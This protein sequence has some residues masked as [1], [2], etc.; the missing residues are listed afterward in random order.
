MGVEAGCQ[1][2]PE[3]SCNIVYA[4]S[5]PPIMWLSPMGMPDMPGMSEAEAVARARVSGGAWAGAMG[6]GMGMG[7]DWAKAGPAQR[8]SAV[9]TAQPQARRPLSR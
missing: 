4:P 5:I 7:T 6:M 1:E 2:V 8:K 9:M 3:A